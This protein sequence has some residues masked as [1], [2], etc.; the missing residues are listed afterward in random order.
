MTR[1]GRVC[2]AG[3]ECSRPQGQGRPLG[4]S[5]WSDTRGLSV[6]HGMN[7]GE[8]VP[9]VVRQ[10]GAPG[11]SHGRPRGHAG[12]LGFLLDGWTLGSDVM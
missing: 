6:E 11:A 5:G 4:S 10:T 2:G 1:G 7:Q 12:G 9:S 3:G 8:A